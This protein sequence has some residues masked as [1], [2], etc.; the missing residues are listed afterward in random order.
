MKNQ[1]VRKTTFIFIQNQQA[2]YY[3]QW[4]VL[5]HLMIQ[6]YATDTQ[7]KTENTSSHE[8]TQLPDLWTQMPSRGGRK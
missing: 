8:A 3:Q 7:I 2:N 1:A 4:L 6:H 5:N